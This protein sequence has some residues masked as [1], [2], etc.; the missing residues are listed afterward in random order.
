MLFRL[1]TGQKRDVIMC[2]SSCVVD[3]LYFVFL[4]G[5]KS[6]TEDM[7]AILNADIRIGKFR[8]KCVSQDVRHR[9]VFLNKILC[10]PLYL[11]QGVYR[12]SLII[13]KRYTATPNFLF[14]IPTTLAKICFARIVINRSK[15]S[16][17]KPAPPFRN[18]TFSD[19]LEM[20]RTY[21]K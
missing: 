2:L 19:H 5:V 9:T 14:R 3:F 18:P 20:R 1:Q 7:S 8:R 17:F 15:I 6:G 12:K 13:F 16:L 4:F 11:Y 21:A 10:S